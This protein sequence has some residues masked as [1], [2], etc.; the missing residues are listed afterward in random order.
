MAFSAGLSFSESDFIAEL[1]EEMATCM[2]KEV[3]FS[4]VAA[5]PLLGKV[6]AITQ[7]PPKAIKS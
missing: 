7:T 5:A 3:P 2:Q 1:E 4:A 6:A